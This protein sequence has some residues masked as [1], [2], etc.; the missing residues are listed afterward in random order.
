MRRLSE[1][2]AAEDRMHLTEDGFVIE[3]YHPPRRALRVNILAMGDVGGT[4]ALALRLTGADIV[5]SIGIC[6]LDDKVC[7]RY[8]MELNQIAMPDDPAAFPPVE[9]ISKEAL[10][11]GDVFL[12]CATRGVPP[13][14]ASAEK[15]GKDVRMAQLEGNLKLIAGFAE[16]AAACGYRGDFFVV[17][18][19]VD[20][21]CKQAILCG[22]DP[23][24][25]KGFGLG[26]MHARAA[27]YAAK[28]PV[29]AIY[30]REGR[31]FGPHGQDLVIA[32]SIRS[33]DDAN[34]LA[35]TQQ[36][37]NTN[38]A[39]RALG[40][41]PYLAPACSSGALSL[42]EDMRGHWHY[43]SAYFGE[44]NRGAFLGMRCRRTED[45]LL[46]E[47]LPLDERLFA[48]IERAY[49]NLEALV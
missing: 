34:A 33:Y 48:R 22:L 15:T 7:A 39:I 42:L 29:F 32:D 24:Q 16:Q 10:F 11:D 8:E 18:D 41:K 28:D 6:D 12:F 19:P 13:V 40:F 43:S 27:Y 17:S 30:L 1:L 46:V 21:L 26:V 9:V 45:G 2:F 25:V 44:G 3:G 35:L 20:P 37:V 38:L 5:R 23:G 36:T 49:R 47:N 14:E 31:A 4:L